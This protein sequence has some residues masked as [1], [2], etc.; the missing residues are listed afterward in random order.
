MHKGLLFLPLCAVFVAHAQIHSIDW[1]IGASHSPVCVS[2]GT[3]PMLPCVKSYVITDLTIN[4]ETCMVAAP[5]LTCIQ[6]G[7]TWTGTHK[8]SA[9]AA[10]LDTHGNAANSSATPAVSISINVLIVNTVTGM[11]ATRTSTTVT[12]KWTSDG[13]PKLPFC[14]GAIYPCV[15]GIIGKDLTNGTHETHVAPT[16]LKVSWKES[17]TRGH[18]IGVS[19]A[20]ATTPTS[21]VYSKWAVYTLQ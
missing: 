5:T 16:A 14:N 1:T 20:V 6:T 7:V 15:H 17:N 11:V 8:F 4:S 18:R 2:S 21:Y 3:Q 12:A 13:N 9:V 19:V 10:G